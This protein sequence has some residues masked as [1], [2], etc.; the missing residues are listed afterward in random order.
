[1]SKLTMVNQ[2]QCPSQCQTKYQETQ[3][4]PNDQQTMIEKV[5]KVIN[6]TDDVIQRLR[7]SNF[8]DDLSK[9]KIVSQMVRELYQS[10]SSIPKINH[11]MGKMMMKM[12]TGGKKNQR[13][14]RRNKGGRH[15]VAHHPNEE[16]CNTESVTEM[17]EH[18]EDDGNF[19]ILLH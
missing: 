5:G 17:I 18:M 12:I 15:P 3:N 7:N 4:A 14:S 16:H 6:D 19:K 10:F 11:F 13:G 9:Y 1:M 2:D 8:N